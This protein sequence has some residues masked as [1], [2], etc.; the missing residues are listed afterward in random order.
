MIFAEAT[1]FNFLGKGKDSGS[2]EE[3]FFFSIFLKVLGSKELSPKISELNPDLFTNLL[4]TAGF[5]NS[6]YS[7]S[8]S[9]KNLE[10]SASVIF[11][12]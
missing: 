4:S 8:T 6:I 11:P 9:L 10:G 5:K 12:H 2:E 1:G 3:S 7:S